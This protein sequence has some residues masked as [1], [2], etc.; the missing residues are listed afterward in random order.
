MNHSLLPSVAK[1]TL[2][3]R[4]EAAKAAISECSRVDECKDWGDKAA[5]L[6]SYAKQSGDK[7]M[8]ETAMRIR[9]RAIKRCGEL[10]KEVEKASGGQPYQKGSTS[11]GAPTSRRSVAEQAGMSKDQAV[12]AIRVA[13]VPKESFEKQVEGDN[14]PS[15]TALAEQG[16]A[17]SK[18]VPHYEQRGMTKEAFQAGMYFRPHLVRMAGYTKDFDPQ[19][20]ADGS[21]PDE[22]EEIRRNIE[23]VE[24]YFDKLI[25]KL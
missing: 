20:V 12:T 5:A 22:R 21:T 10:L 11:R 13:N 14:P 7:T 17:K 3:E 16:K 25:A 8:E 23:T 2:P 15:I 9:A 18:A 1:A 6:A 4:Y 24:R 19:L